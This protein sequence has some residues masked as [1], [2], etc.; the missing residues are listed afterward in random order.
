[1]LR[2]M[3]ARKLVFAMGKQLVTLKAGIKEFEACLGRHNSSRPARRIM[4]AGGVEPPSEKRNASEPTCL[5][6]FVRFASR[7]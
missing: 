6:Q 4:E 5:S 2:R 1:M 3:Q 7:D